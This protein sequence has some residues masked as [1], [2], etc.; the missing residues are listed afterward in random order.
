MAAEEDIKN[1]V[2]VV[3]DKGEVSQTEVS[4]D[5]PVAAASNVVR[6][7]ELDAFHE[8]LDRLANQTSASPP[9]PS[10][11]V[12][13][14]PDEPLDHDD[15]A[16]L[17]DAI[18]LLE[19]TLDEATAAWTGGGSGSG[20]GGSGGGGRGGPASPG[21]SPT[22]PPPPTP[23]GP[24][25]PPNQPPAPPSLPPLPPMPLP[26]VGGAIGALGSGLIVFE[27][28]NQY[29]KA[30]V[31]IA[32]AIDQHILS[33][34]DDIRIFSPDVMVA[35]VYTQLLQ[36]QEMMHRANTIGPDVAA[37]QRNRAELEAKITRLVTQLESSFLPFVVLVMRG[38]NESATAILG[39]LVV[40]ETMLKRTAPELAS[41]IRVIMNVIRNAEENKFSKSELDLFEQLDALVTGRSMGPVPKV[42]MADFPEAEG[43]F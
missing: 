21:G 12:D 30:L 10:G 37:Y 28:M 32:K 27:A 31:D 38:M 41:V 40:I 23:P 3:N 24:P 9:S 4:G 42:D 8:Y 39:V 36:M 25:P 33:L 11:G 13:G 16:E 22:P 35:D 43:V 20:S 29:L 15:L 14:I 5:D 1:I 2:I 34:A 17:T 26:P 19:E 18:E 7:Q 6:D